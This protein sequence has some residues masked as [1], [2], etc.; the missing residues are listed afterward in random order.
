[1]TK[2]VDFYFDFGSPTAYLAWKGL[3]ELQQHHDMDLVFHPM[4]LGGVHKATGNVPPGAVPLKGKYMLQDILRCAKRQ[5]VP[6]TFNK[7]FPINTLPVMRGALAAQKLGCFDS[8]VDAVFH[9]F[10]RDNKNMGDPAVI[11]GVLSAAGLD[12]EALLALTQDPDIKQALIQAT[13]DAVARGIFGAPTMFVGDE[14]FFGQDRVDFV[15]EALA[16]A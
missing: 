14:M 9:A 1:M 13:E 10:W 5:N 7:A 6:L 2:T 11:A 16:T 3:L 8:Y 15:A 4:L 12:V